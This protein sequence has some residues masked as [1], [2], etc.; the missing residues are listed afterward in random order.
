MSAPLSRRSLLTGL[1]AA[2]AG[3]PFARVAAGAA[4]TTAAARGRIRTA[5]GLGM[6]GEGASLLEKFQLLAELGFDGVELDAPNGFDTGE[7]CAARDASGLVIH[8]VVDSVH[9]SKPLSHP[10]PAVRAE[11]Q[12]GLQRALRDAKAYGAEIVLL[13][14]AVVSKEVSYDDAWRRAQREIREA[15]PLAAELGVRIAIENVW[16]NFLLSPLEFARFV[17][18]LDSPWAGAYFDAG[19]VVRYG[20]P[21]QWIRILGP[22]ILRLHVKEYSRKLENEQGPWRGFD[23]ELLEGDNDWPAVI[24]A[25]REVGF[26]GWATL[27]V[28]GGDRDRLAFLADRLAAVK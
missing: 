21:E 15:L 9:W 14:P 22:R 24:T 18:E 17:D 26:A 19:N 25:L 4:A 10:D 12:A 28:R 6:V 27:E 16:N 23:V 20:W 5:C 7:L 13:V 3:I 11:G 1:A 2:G 8:G